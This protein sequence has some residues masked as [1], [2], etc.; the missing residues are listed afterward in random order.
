MANFFAVRR[1]HQCGIA[2][3]LAIPTG[4]GSAL[5]PTSLK[6]LIAI[7]LFSCAPLAYGRDLTSD[8][9]RT[10]YM[11]A[12]SVDTK[13]LEPLSLR[14]LIMFEAGKP[15][16]IQL[17]GPMTRVIRAALQQIG[18]RIGDYLPRNTY[19]V[20]LGG[21]NPDR[22]AELDFI[23]WSGEYQE[24]WKLEPDLGGRQFVTPERQATAANDQVV[25]T[26]TL[27][28]EKV[29]TPTMEAI[30]ALDEAVVHTVETV[31]G[32][33]VITATLSYENVSDLVQMEDI[34]YIEEY[35]ELTYRNATARWI[36]QSNVED[37]TPLYDNGLHGEGQIVG[38]LDGS[39]D[40]THCSLDE[41]KILFN[42]AQSGN[43]IHG[44]HVACTI[45]G[46]SGDFE[47]T[48]GVAYLANIVFNTLPD[49]TEGASTLSERL[50]L[51]HRQG[52]RIHANSWGSDGTNSY[53]ALCRSFDAFSY[54]HEDD[55]VCIAATNLS[56]LKNPE[57]AKNLLVVGASKD[58]PDQDAYCAGGVGPTV[59]GRQKPDVCAPGCNT[60][61]ALAGTLCD[62]GPLTGT[63]AASATVAG[64]A[65]LVRQYFV[66][67]YY[68]GGVQNSVDGFVPSGALI[69]AAIINSA[70][71]MDLIGDYP[72]DL[73]G[74][75]RVLT[76]DVLYFAGDNRN[77][78]VLADLRNK[79]GL[80]MGDRQTFAFFVKDVSERLKVTLVWTDPPSSA[81]TGN[82]L[83]L[84]N[85]LDLE[86]TA[87]DGKVYLGND[88]F[89]G[90]STTGD[91]SDDLN[92]VE[93][94]H[95]DA[96]LHGEWKA[97]IKATTINQGRQGFALI[98]T[99]N[100]G[101]SDPDPAPDVERDSLKL[102]AEEPP[103]GS[104]VNVLDRIWV[105]FTEPVT[106]VTA[107]QLHVNGSPAVTLV[108]PRNAPEGSVGPFQFSGFEVPHNGVVEVT[109]AGGSATDTAGNALTDLAWTYQVQDC[110]DNHLLVDQQDSQAGT[111]IDC[112]G[113]MIP[114]LCDPD[115]VVAD[116]GPDLS[117]ATGEVLTLGGSTVA[118]GGNP[119][120]SYEWTLMGEFADEYVTVVNPTF[121]PT[122]ADV[123]VVRLVVTDASGCT[124]TDL[125]RVT[126]M[127]NNLDRAPRTQVDFD[128]Y[129][130][131][132]ASRFMVAGGLTLMAM[133]VCSLTLRSRRRC[134]P[135]RDRQSGQEARH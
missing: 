17:K 64:V 119:P 62:V 44:T 33:H 95:I 65:A 46:D 84:I 83:A 92:N 57:N 80:E 29:A 24:N 93:Q 133:I 114:D 50:K 38:L 26:V 60:M 61:S 118:T 21:V 63:S 126:V 45:A 90:V 101:N 120:Y 82:N 67:G 58:T 48:R 131:N 5:R 121:S 8:D 27:F 43:D 81:G 23:Q 71:N 2:R 35:P 135:G 19:I 36:V 76:D 49:F 53:D 106:G 31:G 108:A 56:S 115:M 73:E 98:A 20:Y 9:G 103:A 72:S 40:Q 128:R 109:F 47:D 110:D 55:L 100:L 124:A 16:V 32:N 68:P 69:K 75:G 104:I 7:T 12:G 30:G 85:N 88:F 129:V 59:D 91:V 15:Y 97:T 39:P 3:I 113:N 134:R 130:N 132:C 11:N 37:L 123:Y 125:T 4:A 122:F 87:P 14:S 51:H 54:E 96:P 117:M 25:V 70:T 18:V 127:D 74:W 10:L 22:L 89:E 52:A 34:Q 105:T 1:C 77:L 112:N 42:N 111:F 94:V 116:A 66:D 78:A 41:G 107:D 13:N 102:A 28:K 86:V 99:G 79:S 6:S